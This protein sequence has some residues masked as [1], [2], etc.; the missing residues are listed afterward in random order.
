MQPKE[1]GGLA[2]EWTLTLDRVKRLAINDAQLSAVAIQ[3][4]FRY[5]VSS[6][7]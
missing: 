1:N 6:E 5:W 3:L 4:C 2:G 7:H